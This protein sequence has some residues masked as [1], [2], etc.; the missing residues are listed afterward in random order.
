MDFTGQVGKNLGQS[1]LKKKKIK[2]VADFCLTVC[3]TYYFKCILLYCL[4]SQSSPSQRSSTIWVGLQMQVPSG[5]MHTTKVVTD[6][7]YVITSDVN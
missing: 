7:D 3:M 4:C 5:P 2:F 1:F 6:Q